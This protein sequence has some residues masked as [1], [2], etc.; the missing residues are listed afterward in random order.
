LKLQLL[1][2]SAR[3]ER[4]TP[5]L[6]RCGLI[7][8]AIQLSTAFT[9]TLTPQLKRCGLIEALIKRLPDAFQVRLRS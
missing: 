8:A 6:K 5:Q 3:S 7:E 9:R 2:I 4:P 1:A